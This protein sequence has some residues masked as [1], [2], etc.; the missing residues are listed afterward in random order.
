MA[1]F[2]T[3]LLPIGVQTFDYCFAEEK[4]IFFNLLGQ[5]TCH[6]DP[7]VIARYEKGKH[8][9]FFFFYRISKFGHY[10]CQDKQCGNAC[11]TN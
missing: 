8:S 2:T 9:I 3:R 11:M 6:G 10:P 5:K 1:K 7:D 4:N